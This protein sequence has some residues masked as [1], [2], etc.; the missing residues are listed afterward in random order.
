M[1]RTHTERMD[2]LHNV[3]IGKMKPKLCSF[4][5]AISLQDSDVSNWI[6]MKHRLRFLYPCVPT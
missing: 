6:N 5:Q 3:Q 2:A 4:A 1:C